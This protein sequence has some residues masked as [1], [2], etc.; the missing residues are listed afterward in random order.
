MKVH[1]AADIIAV[2]KCFPGFN[3]MQDLSDMP[4]VLNERFRIVESRGRSLVT[5]RI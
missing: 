1:D 4:D 2:D 5:E 3:V